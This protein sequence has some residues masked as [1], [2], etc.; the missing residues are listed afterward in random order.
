MTRGSG[1]SDL[2]FLTLLYNAAADL[3]R[4]NVRGMIQISLIDGKEKY[5]GLK[6][7]REAIRFADVKETYTDENGNEKE[8]LMTSKGVYIR[9]GEQVLFKKI[10]VRFE[11]NDYVLS[12]VHPESEYLQLYDDIMLEGVDKDD[13]KE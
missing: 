7:P 6:V 5:E 12:K 3:P 1:V 13:E 4:A 9:K 2:S 8:K 10:D 11:G